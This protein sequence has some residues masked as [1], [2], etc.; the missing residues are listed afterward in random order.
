[1]K[2]LVGCEFTGMVRTELTKLGHY[3][4]SC[5][6]TP[7]ER[8]GRHRRCDVRDLL[9]DGWDALIAFPPCQYLARS[10]LHW[11]HKQPGRIERAELAL[12]FVQTLMDAPIG[13]IAIENPYGLISTRI[14]PPDQVI[15]P[16]QF[17]HTESKATCLWL[18]NLPK[19]VPT[20]VMAKPEAGWDNHRADGQHYM[21]SAA[22]R[23]KDRSRT[24]YGVAKAMADQWF[25]PAAD[26][27]R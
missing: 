1:M 27:W 10:G 6:L 13:K 3:A 4:V 8:P 23:A 24:Y 20:E 26:Y 12:E 14:R 25:G 15:H 9:E 18:K 21:G 22:T 16:W 19:L 5:D 11:L 7:T 2:I 17:G